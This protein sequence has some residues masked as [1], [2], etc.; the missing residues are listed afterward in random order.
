M[1]VT[2]PEGMAAKSRRGG[3]PQ[4]ADLIKARIQQLPV[5]AEK[6]RQLVR[7]F[8]LAFPDGRWWD[9][10]DE[11]LRDLW[12]DEEWIDPIY[13]YCRVISSEGRYNINAERYRHTLAQVDEFHMFI[14]GVT[15]RAWRRNKGR[16]RLARLTPAEFEIVREYV[17]TGDRMRPISTRACKARGYASAIAAIK[18]FERARAKVD[19]HLSRYEFRLFRLHG[20]PDRE[21]KAFQFVPSK[22]VKYC[23]IDPVIRASQEST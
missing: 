19:L 20:T 23:L 16:P 17:E 11:I 2:E 10:P 13:P 6:R 8:D 3:Q 7:D 18:L 14:D 12:D 1:P 9:V 5:D 15:R 21:A 4:D 22:N